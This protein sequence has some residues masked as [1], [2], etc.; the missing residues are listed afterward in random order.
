MFGDGE[1]VGHPEQDRNFHNFSRKQVDLVLL[2]GSSGAVPTNDY[3]AK[4]FMDSGAS[5]ININPDES[6]NYIVGTK[7]FLRMKSREALMKLDSELSANAI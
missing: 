1:Y 5:V 4:H 3:I 7:N 6:S 2:V